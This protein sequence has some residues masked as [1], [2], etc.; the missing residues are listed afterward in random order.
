MA[1]RNPSDVFLELWRARELKT[2]E[3]FRECAEAWMAIRKMEES[4]AA[5][6]RLKRAYYR[7]R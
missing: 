3:A 7:D 5:L 2:P 1:E 4:R 6:D